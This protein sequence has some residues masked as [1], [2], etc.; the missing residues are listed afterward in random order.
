MPGLNLDQNLLS[1]AA[2]FQ[3]GDWAQG[4]AA[5]TLDFR[6]AAELDRG[7]NLELGVGVMALLEAGLHKF[8]AVDA[9]LRAQAS[10]DLKAQVQLPMDLF[11]EAGVA[12]RLVAAAQASAVARLKIGLSVRDFIQL[13]EQDRRIDDI[14]LRLLVILLEEVKIQAGVHGRVAFSA[15]AYANLALTARLIEDPNQGLKPGFTIGGGYGVGLKAGAGWGVFAELGLI[16]PPRFVRRSVDAIVEDVFQRLGPLLPDEPARR[17]LEFLRYPAKIALRAS[18]EL[19]MALAEQAPTFSGDGAQLAKQCLHVVLEEAQRALM[20]E[21]TRLSLELFRRA[22]LE[23]GVGPDEWEDSQAQREDFAARLEALPA[24]PFDLTAENAAYWSGLVGSAIDLGLAFGDDAT[25]GWEEPLSV[26]WAASTLAMLAVERMSSASARISALGSFS[27][28]ARVQP[29]AGALADELTPPPAILRHINASLS[30]NT[31][32]RLDQED[33]LAFLVRE[34]ALETLVRE[35]PEVRDL[36]AAVA[37]PT[38]DGPIAAARTILTNLGAFV[39]GPDGELDAQASLSV[40]AEAMRAYI[41]VRLRQELAPLLYEAT[42]QDPDLRLY[43][44]DVLIASMDFAVG[45][46]FQRVIDWSVG[47]LGYRDA[48]REACSSIVMKL[49]GRSLVVTADVL[50]TH[51]MKEMSGTLVELATHANDDGGVAET[52]ASLT[53]AQREDIADIVEET[54][55]ICSEVLAPLPDARRATIR[56]LLYELIDTAPTHPDGSWLD[57]LRQDVAFPS[58]ETWQRMTRLSDELGAQALD[59]LGLFFSRVLMRIAE[60]VVQGILELIES[61]VETIEEWAAM[62]V[63]LAAELVAL[64]QAL[65]AIIDAWVDAANLEL[66]RALDSLSDCLALLGGSSLEQSV[67]SSITGAFVAAATGALGMV[68]GYQALSASQRDKVANE[69]ARVADA[70]VSASLLGPAL[71]GVGVL[72]T[73]VH[74]VLDEIVEALDELRAIEPGADAGAEILRILRR[75][76]VDSARAALG[77]GGVG[78]D[79]G[80]SVHWEIPVPPTWGVT[81][82]RSLPHWPW[83]EPREWGWIDHPPIVVDFPCNLGRIELP[84]ED[85]LSPITVA[86]E[87][88]AGLADLTNELAENL[89]HFFEKEDEARKSEAR[90]AVAEYQHEEVERIL[91]EA[92]VR[93]L[94]IEVLSPLPAAVYDA[95]VDVEILLAGVPHSFLGTGELEAQRIHLWLN[96]DEIDLSDVAIEP[97]GAGGGHASSDTSHAARADRAREQYGGRWIQTPRPGEAHRSSS[98]ARWQRAVGTQ[99][100]GSRRGSMGAKTAGHMGNRMREYDPWRRL[101]PQERSATLGESREG[102]R[103]SLRLPLDRVAEGVNTL[104][105]AVLASREETS[106]TTIAFLVAPPPEANEDLPDGVRLP[107]RW[108]PDPDDLGRALRDRLRRNPDD[109]VPLPSADP[110]RQPKPA[111]KPRPRADKFAPLSKRLR[112]RARFRSQVRNR[113][114]RKSN[115]RELAAVKARLLSEGALIPGE[116]EEAS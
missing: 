58:P 2:G 55:Q 87:A 110:I 91:D 74:D 50:T 5:A 49:C 111:G 80:F 15:M 92:A 102:L 4:E 25:A 109:R 94:G 81:K 24:E 18:F 35:V 72:S 10:A 97:I 61:F 8:L 20:E 17:V 100:A 113:E 36:L 64:I 70:A 11:G 68:P 69:L 85:L 108:M 45:V 40:V 60:L 112:A 57:E 22:L 90:L 29:Y 79:L 9:E 75:K 56:T 84:V 107:G 19:G 16:E 63:A 6:G 62:I 27:A 96:E 23:I 98:E 38:A 46:A 106:T 32:G 31:D 86:L 101:G 28:G 115:Q 54:L 93:N 41:D 47:G 77:G 30:R 105:V 53:G 88:L 103:L 3:A 21:L 78:I 26:M 37:G 76:I 12:V 52:L 44:D 7:I 59:Y 73:R 43:I 42:E 99:G 66:A 82:W 83:R 114:R 89:V 39:P 14:A 13:A 48:L 104:S 67:R 116:P 33:V 1:A 71:S 34:V 51:A 65:P 95:A